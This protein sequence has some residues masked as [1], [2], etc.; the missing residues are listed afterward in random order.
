MFFYHERIFIRW[1]FN[2]LYE[3]IADEICCKLKDGDSLLDVGCGHGFLLFEIQKRNKEIKLTGIDISESVIKKT[4]KRSKILG[5][6]NTTFLVS[7]P[8]KFPFNDN[9][10]T[11]AVST[12][13]FHLWSEPVLMLDEIY[14]VLK[15]NGEFIIYDFNGDND[16]QKDNLNYIEKCIKEAPL[17][18]RKLSMED[19]RWDCLLFGIYDKYQ[20]EEIVKKSIFR[21]A[22]IKIRGIR[23]S[24]EHFLIE[25]RLRKSQNSK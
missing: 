2:Q 23:K 1:F 9:V 18:V 12:F 6:E 11:H 14:R 13:S 25:T 19:A 20:V 17:F 10:F 4:R 16:Y 22:E 15:P 24:G 3:S 8:A 7:E 21:K 5:Y